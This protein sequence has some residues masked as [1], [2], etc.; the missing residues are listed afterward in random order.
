MPPAQA[1][2]SA[3]PGPSAIGS[4]A[5]PPP[6]PGGVY[7]QLASAQSEEGAFSEWKRISGH[8]KD[9]LSALSPSVSR[10]DIA[11]KGTYYRLRAGP[12]PDHAAAENLCAALAAR[13]VGC[14]LVRP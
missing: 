8:N 13:H 6:P 1:V 14:M 11:D 5:E 9:L 12:L 4:A 3:A 7:V 2:A 10:A